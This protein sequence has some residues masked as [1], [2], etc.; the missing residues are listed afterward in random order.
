M[1]N[2]LGFFFALYTLL[3]CPTTFFAVNPPLF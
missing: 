2:D 1:K 3:I